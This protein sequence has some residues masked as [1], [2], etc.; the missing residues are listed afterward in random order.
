[1]KR[2]Y[3]SKDTISSSSEGDND[4]PQ[5]KAS[6]SPPSSLKKVDTEGAS[7]KSK[8]PAPEKPDADSNE[9]GSF[10]LELS[11]KRRVIVRKW[12]NST[13]VDIREYWNDSNNE[14][15]PGKK[16]TYE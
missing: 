5:S 3:T 14:L 8:S 2:R 11:A 15:K 7:K 6:A 4:K 13:L 12:K 10:V 9:D 1:M 16:G